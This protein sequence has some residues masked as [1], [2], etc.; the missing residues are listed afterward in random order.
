MIV[1]DVQNSIHS[2]HMYFVQAIDFLLSKGANISR[3]A[4]LLWGLQLWGNVTPLHVSII[5]GHWNSVE[6]F[7]THARRSGAASSLAKQ[8]RLT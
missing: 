5:V 2:L 8:V 7:L 1:T 4:Q 3:R 6:A